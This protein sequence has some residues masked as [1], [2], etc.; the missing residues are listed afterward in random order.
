[1]PERVR[2]EAILQLLADGCFH[3]GQTIAE[4]IG[5]S[6]S[7]VWKH[8][9][10]LRQ[11]TGLR[12]DA[13]TGRGYRL[14]QALELLDRD[15]ILKRLDGGHRDLLAD[16]QVLGSVAST[17]ALAQQGRLTVGQAAAWLAE[18][19]RAG[20]GRR[21]RG[22]HSPYGS[23]LYLSLAWCFELPLAHLS[24][25]SLATGA[26]LAGLLAEHG[27]HGH[28]LKWPNDLLWRGRKLAGILLEVR[29]E[30]DG[31]ATAVIGIGIN[32]DL[33][34]DSAAQIDQPAAGLRQAGAAVQRNRLAG[35]LLDRLLGL[36][37]RYSV[38]GLTPFLPAW[39]Q[40]D[41]FLGEQVR[42]VG[43]RSELQGESL[44]IGEDGGLRLRTADG[45][46]TVYAGELSLRAAA[47]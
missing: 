13:V 43:Q 28:G 24:G 10:A 26:V 17:N 44:G 9:S 45:E 7:A 29:G 38:E 30:T 21:G 5:C 34:A 33:D 41:L 31:P 47:P 19:Q 18:H 15:L 35:D 23:N 46:R 1:M 11:H 16:C 42:L 22:W 36:C 12:I 14:A 32:L 3:S 6:R 4:V 37:Q 40:Y 8:I 2:R 20:R 27:L 25:L 39:R